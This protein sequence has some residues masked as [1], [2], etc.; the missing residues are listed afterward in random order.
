M[1]RNL[2]RGAFL[3]LF[4]GAT[5]WAQVALGEVPPAPRW[6]T[7]LRGEPVAIGGAPAPACTVFAFFVSAA[8][9]GAFAAD[10]S[11]LAGLARR[12]AERGVCVVAV[13]TDSN[14]GPLDAWAGCRVV[15]TDDETVLGWLGPDAIALPVV[16]LDRKGTVVFRGTAASG[17]VDAVEAVVGDKV[18]LERE[19]AAAAARHD[20]AT[21]FDDA[22]KNGLR[23]QLEAAL[24]HAP[25][26]GFLL[27]LL[28]L[29]EVQKAVDAEAGRRVR[30][31]ALRDLAGESRPLAV[32][33]DLA[34]RGDPRDK[35][36]AGELAQRLLPATVE[37]PADVPL[38]LARLRALVLSGE[39]REVGRHA[40]RIQKA[41]LASPEHCL[42]FAGILT[43][44]RDAMVHRD[45]AA[46]ALAKAE[47]AGA[48]PRLVAAARYGTL[49]RCAEDREGARKLLST[50][51]G[52]TEVRSQI[53]ND[54]WYLMTELPTMGRYDWFAAGLA[55]RML[56]QRDDMDYFEFD[57]AAMAMFL[58]GRVADAVELQKTAV[59]RGGKGNPQYEERL[60][61]YEASLSPAPR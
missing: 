54:C 38:Q 44:D 15:T 46:R 36:L 41:V 28:Y 61:R 2:L 35:A 24:S 19:Q 14:V 49:L 20:L 32:F 60:H 52:D 17:L 40:M 10:A 7:W 22:S 50:Y 45:L 59:A 29:T 5:L 55:E 6:Q 23:E 53:N 33:A 58:V 4:G 57:T 26:D 1:V 43:M 11:Y 31:R 27:G 56:E 13:V 18:D 21:T 12:H 47:A 9:P 37:A 25:H 16:V 34:L 48:P 42:D 39:G 51:L 8:A 3:V 30:D